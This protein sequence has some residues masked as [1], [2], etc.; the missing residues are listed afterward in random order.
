MDE[1]V[2]YQIMT[3]LELNGI[4][5]KFDIDLDEIMTLIAKHPHEPE[6]ENA[7]QETI[8]KRAAVTNELTR[9]DKENDH[10][11]VLWPQ[12]L[13]VAGISFRL[14]DL[15]KLL[16][17][18]VWLERE[19]TNTHDPLAI[20]VINMNTEGVAV[21]HIGYVPREIAARIPNTKLPAKGRIVWQSSD[22]KKP[23]LRIAI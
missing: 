22:P 4:I 5:N 16:S 21:F 17:N 13:P 1:D 18:R 12:P 23:G 8:K 14:D 15:G 6:W 11:G 2:N 20:K 10:L 19:P 7:F 9:R 3:D